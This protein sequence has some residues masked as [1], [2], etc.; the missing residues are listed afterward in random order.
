MQLPTDPVPE[1]RMVMRQISSKALQMSNTK[2]LAGRTA[3]ITGAS[4]GL[5]RAMAIELAGAGA[6]VALVS[7]DREKLGEAA[8]SIENSGGTARVFVA[9]VAR[10]GDVVQ[11]EKEV[12]ATFGRVDILINNAGINLRK[13]LIEFTLDEWYRVMETNVTSVFLMCRAFVPH[14]RN[15]GY[16]RVINIASIMASISYPER[17]A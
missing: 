7:R 11:L 8:R 10:E 2:N 4:R 15:K 3:V 12:A 6:N 17:G 5:G 16:G 14:M 9:D 1:G 13:P